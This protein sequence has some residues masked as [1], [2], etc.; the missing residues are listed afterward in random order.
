MASECIIAFPRVLRLSS[1]S[2][3]RHLQC[4]TGTDAPVSYNK[5]N[6]RGSRWFNGT[7][8]QYWTFSTLIRPNDRLTENHECDGW[9]NFGAFAARS[10]HPGGV[11]M[12]MGDGSTRFIAETINYQLY[13]ALGT[14][15]NGEAANLED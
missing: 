9:S 6:A 7:S 10:R 5:S 2:Q 15:A 13:Q 1:S 4:I 12:C 11:N 14:M 8:N 3:S